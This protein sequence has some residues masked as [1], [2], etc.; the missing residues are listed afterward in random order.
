MLKNPKNEIQDGRR[1]HYF[2]CSSG[3]RSGQTSG[4]ILASDTSKRV[5]WHKDVPFGL[6]ND[7]YFSFNPK[8]A[9]NPNFWTL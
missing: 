3:S 4:P 7:K 1:R 5:V 9:Q 6:K 8:I 2:F